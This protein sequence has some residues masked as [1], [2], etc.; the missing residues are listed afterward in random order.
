V[1][2]FTNESNAPMRALLHGE[3]WTPS[4]VLT[5]LDEGDPGHVFFHDTSPAA[6]GPRREVPNLRQ[7]HCRQ[8]TVDDLQSVAP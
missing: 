6:P 2:A 8:S 7:R 3:G 1:L 4:G 5:G